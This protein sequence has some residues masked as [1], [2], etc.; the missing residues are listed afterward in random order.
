M[1][2]AN[3]TTTTICTICQND[4]HEYTSI[5]EINNHLARI[6]IPS[7]VYL[8]ILFVSGVIGNVMVLLVYGFRIK[9]TAYAILILILA[10]LDLTTCLFGVPYHILSVVYPLMFVW[11]GFCKIVSF[12]LHFATISS[13]FIVNV[14]AYDRYRKI[15][16]PFQRQLSLTHI[17]TASFVIITVAVILASPVLA[18]FSS[19]SEAT[20]ISNLTGTVCFIR[21]DLSGTHFHQIYEG[22]ISLLFIMLLIFMISMYFPV[23]RRILR[24]RALKH[25]TSSAASVTAAGTSKHSH[26]PGD[27]NDKNIRMAYKRKTQEGNFY[28]S[29]ESTNDEVKTHCDTT[30]E[31][32]IQIQ[33][34]GEFSKD[35]HNQGSCSSISKTTSV[36]V[37]KCQSLPNPIKPTNTDLETR[38]I[39]ARLRVT[40]MLFV[41][42]SV[43]IISFL[44]YLTT[45]IIS[46][47]NSEI[48]KNLSEAQLVI[49][50]FLL[51]TY[52]ISS[53]SNPIVYWF[54]DKKFKS[55]L[56]ILFRNVFPCCNK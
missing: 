25:K 42:T 28:S 31:K 55:E 10:A 33:I 19:T 29:E 16:K 22:T 27:I 49:Y 40:I 5:L 14:I 36:I 35:I 8:C 7:A 39:T 56:C 44:P 3:S 23:G 52:L 43:F 24:L 2:Y 54:L 51:R 21:Q 20:G 13:A 26:T 45:E 53:M 47:L 38:K 11:N 6:L 32:S 37:E 12:L 41:I 34:I 1:M 17:K 48:W 4:T 50:A 30:V 15:C 9:K 18:L 46:S